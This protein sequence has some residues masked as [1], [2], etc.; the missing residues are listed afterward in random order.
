MNDFIGTSQILHGCSV[1]LFAKSDNPNCGRGEEMHVNDLFFFLMNAVDISIS[2][3]YRTWGMKPRLQGGPRHYSCSLK[4]S[5]HA[6]L[7]NHGHSEA[8]DSSL[9]LLFK[10]LPSD[11]HVLSAKNTV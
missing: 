9:F 5:E 4:H 1:F 6:R 11:W 7:L 2:N 8:L 10:T 3:I